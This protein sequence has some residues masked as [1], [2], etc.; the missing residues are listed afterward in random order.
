MKKLHCINKNVKLDMIG[1]GP[2]MNDTNREVERLGLQGIVKLHGHLSNPY[3]LISK[4][5]V[6]V[7]PSLAEGT[8]RASLEALYLGVPCVLRQVDGNS[9]LI[10]SG[11]NGVL[12]NEDDELVDAMLDAFRI[13]KLQSNNNLLPDFF[14]QK[15]S[16]DR[17]LNLVENS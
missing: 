6:F 1:S 17:Y 2:L 3:F 4:A 14:R 13:S 7:L 5:D 11:F 10:Q 16:S 8:S 12:F 15:E 9:E